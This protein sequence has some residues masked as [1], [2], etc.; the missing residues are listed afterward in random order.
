MATARAARS[1]AAAPD[2]EP[3]VL[4]VPD[5]ELPWTEAELA[6]V[7]EEL[8]GEL[9]RLDGGIAA[10]HATIDDVLRDTGDGVG[11]DQA[12]SGA[13]AFER[14]QEMTLLATVRES[15]FQTER[16]LARIADGT[17]GSC[18]SCGGPIGKLRLQAFPRAVLCVG[19]KQQERR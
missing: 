5:G 16:A 17:F 15:R 14:E 11:D 1:R 9:A 8:R 19:C 13:K 18:E 7:R 2:P 3:P 10:L 6:A 12:D 4:P